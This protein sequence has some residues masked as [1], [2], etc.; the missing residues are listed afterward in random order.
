MKVL[1]VIVTALVSYLL[2]SICFGIIV[3]KK[4]K[5]GDV[6]EHG[7]GS[8]GMTNVLRTYGASKA[9]LTA[10]GDFGKGIVSIVLAR[11]VFMPFFGS[12]FDLGY[13][14][15]LFVLIGHIYPI[16]FKFHGGKGVLTALGIIFL[17][18]PIVFICL[19]AVGLPIMLITRTVSIGSITGAA[20]FP[21]FTLIVRLIQHQPWKTDFLFSL[22]I[23]IIVIYMHRENIDR[24]RKG[25]ENRFDKKPKK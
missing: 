9:A 21:V 4:E 11:Y 23:S 18:D 22:I 16:Y 20:L 12:S 14:A 6:R 15:G 10:L 8:A 13:V 2:G 5:I 25:T 19:I 3:S 1:G 7:S 17:L 24:L